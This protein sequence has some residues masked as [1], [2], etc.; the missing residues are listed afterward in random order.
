MKF[1]DN[2]VFAQLKLFGSLYEAFIKQNFKI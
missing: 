1:L 2:I